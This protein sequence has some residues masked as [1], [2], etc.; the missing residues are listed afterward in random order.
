M[1][2]AIHRL[3]GQPAAIYGIRDRG[4]IKAG[5]YADLLLF[6]PDTV[7]RSPVR[8]TFDLP[9]GERRLTTDALGVHGVWVNGTR[10]V[11]QADTQNGPTLPGVI[12]RSY[13]S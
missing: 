12:L 5:A 8:R 3:T 2:Q 13:D 9:G 7:G 10:I 6:D 1:E 4:Q 11:G